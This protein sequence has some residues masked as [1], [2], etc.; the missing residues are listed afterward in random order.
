[1]PDKI[2]VRIADE[3]QRAG[4]DALPVPASKRTSD[5]TI[6]GMFSQELAAHLAGPGW[7]KKSSLL[8]TLDHNP[9]VR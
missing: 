8:I 6:C 4:S 2:A 3:L 7:I 9:R 5:K 1:M